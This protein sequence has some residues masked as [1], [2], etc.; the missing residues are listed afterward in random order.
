MTAASSVMKSSHC[1][2]ITVHASMW[3][4]VTLTLNADSKGSFFLNF[5]VLFTFLLCNSDQKIFP[6]LVKA[7]DLRAHSMKILIFIAFITFRNICCKAPSFRGSS[8]HFLSF[9]CFQKA[10]I[11]KT[12]KQD[13]HLSFPPD[14]EPVSSVKIFLEYLHLL[15]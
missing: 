10:H 6:Y 5:Y 8:Q 9:S 2:W 14:T 7:E 4:I 13:F 15:S 12:D 3:T 11:H 1:C